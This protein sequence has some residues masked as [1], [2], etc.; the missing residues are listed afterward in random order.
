MV[1]VCSTGETKRVETH[2]EWL[3]HFQLCMKLWQCVFVSLFQR[4]QRRHR[5]QRRRWRHE[6][7]GFDC[8]KMGLIWVHYGF[9][10]IDMHMYWCYLCATRK[11]LCVAVC[12]FLVYLTGRIERERKG[13][14]HPLQMSPEF[15]AEVRRYYIIGPC[16][17]CCFLCKAKDI[18]CMQRKF[19]S[20]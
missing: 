11:P 18:M 12:W 10:P 13:K 1:S 4:Q 5:R 3:W 7:I 8:E 16:N 19:R 15:L 6:K 2:T 20:T 9:E 17:F 14:K